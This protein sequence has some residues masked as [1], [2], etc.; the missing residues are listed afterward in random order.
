MKIA[1]EVSLI[2]LASSLHDKTRLRSSLRPFLSKIKKEGRLAFSSIKPAQAARVTLPVVFIETGGTETPFRKIYHLLPQPILLLSHPGENSL[3]AAL[4]I[5]SYIQNRGGKGMILTGSPAGI[6]RQIAWA[7]RFLLVGQKLKKV[8]LGVIGSP[9]DWLIASRVDPDALRRNWGCRVVPLSLEEVKVGGSLEKIPWLKEIL[10]KGKGPSQ[11]VIRDAARFYP[12]L[13]RIVKKHR[14]N[15]FTIRCFDLLRKTGN[16]PCL[17]LSRFNDEGIPAGCEGDLPTLFSML[18]GYYLT[19]SPAFMANPGSIT[20][21]RNEM[22]FAHCTVPL[23]LT[24]AFSLMTHFE[25]G[26]SVGIRGKLPLGRCV[27]FKVG[28][29]DLSRYF[30]SRGDIMEN[31]TRP[32]M[33]RTQVRIHLEEDVEEYLSHPL[34]NHL[35][36]IPGDHAGLLRA[37]FRVMK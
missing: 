7:G 13:G 22:L 30:I 6:A 37:F 23:T 15:A 18:L 28:G 17:A 4:E 5:L 32:N 27:V 9:S 19:G 35:V 29:P 3:A 1:T 24:T 34:G 26:R 21:E 10:Q 31:L 2:E 33:C 25:S 12:S 16:T 36:I 8:R 14:L 11:R 20:R